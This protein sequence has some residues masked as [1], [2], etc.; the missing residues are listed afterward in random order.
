MTLPRHIQSAWIESLDDATLQL[1]ERELVAV[2]E[3]ER[4]AERKRRGA[5]YDMMKG[6]EALMSA[7]GRW[8]MV[9][10]AMAVRGLRMPTLTA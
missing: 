1:V 5:A 6:P 8:S 7:W 9:R 3:Q 4:D 10:S 2:F